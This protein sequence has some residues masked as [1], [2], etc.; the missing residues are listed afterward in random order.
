MPACGAKQKS[1][2]FRNSGEKKGRLWQAAFCK[3]T[4][5]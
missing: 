1:A 3:R 2:V 4:A 5:Y